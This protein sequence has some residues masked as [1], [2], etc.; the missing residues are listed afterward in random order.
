MIKRLSRSLSFRL[1]A[2][3]LVFG[4]LFVLGT[5][6]ALRWV[7]NSDDI[8]GLISG[9]LSL[10]VSYVLDDIGSPPR[11]DRAKEITRKVPVDIRIMGP[12]LDWA[13]DADFPEL[14]SLDFGPS[15]A[16]SDDPG[17]WVNE[18]RGVEFA[19]RGDH[20]FLK[21]QIDD[22][23]VVVVSP[24]IS[25][26]RSGPPI[27]M[28]I[29]AM[30]IALLTITYLSVR[31]L[32]KPIRAIRQEAAEIGKGNFDRRITNIRSDQL[33]D[34]AAD[35]NSLAA[36][37]E[38]MLDAKRALLLGIS[39]ELRTPLSRLRLIN[40][41]VDDDELHENIRSEVQEME[42]IV[43][44]L[45]EAE[46]LNTQ[47]AA[48]ARST[49]DID[50]LIDELL[51]DYFSRERDRIDVRFVEHGITANI[52]P[53]RVSLMLKNLLSNALRYNAESGTAVK[54]VIDQDGDYVVFQVVDDGPGIP[55][56][57][58]G[59]LYEPFFR[60]DPSRTRGTGG[61]G[62]GLYLASLVATAHGGTI[63]LLNP[64]QPGAQFEIRIPLAA[65]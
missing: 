40:E 51:V 43:V 60:G 50:E 42:K 32:F 17:A 34:L 65:A 38:G 45:L 30:G 49:V 4:A 37:V 19:R 7:Y 53:A 11:I 63:Q 58:A 59:H 3:F 44:E 21:M 24:R 8:R 6:N 22:Y 54:L 47:H 35:I 36:S 27:V 10:H 1:F 31:W 20:N 25:D 15:P 33:G 64:G 12:D 2:I 14:S 56:D 61:T 23:D 26:V 28:L 55:A 41:F 57:Q 13:S 9:H 5:L 16:F 62:L 52:D 48:L 39:H 18:L 46:R 29:V